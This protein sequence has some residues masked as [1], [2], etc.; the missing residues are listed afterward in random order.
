MKNASENVLVFP[1]PSLSPSMVVPVSSRL[2]LTLRAPFAF[3]VGSQ[4]LPPGQ[5]YLE[6]QMSW[7][8]ERNVVVICSTDGEIYH[9]ACAINIP[10][11]SASRTGR[12]VFQRLGGQLYLSEIQAAQQPFLI[13]LDFGAAY[14]RQKQASPAS[15]SLQR[16]ELKLTSAL[17]TSSPVPL[18]VVSA[19]TPQL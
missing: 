9:A 17:P 5:Y 13:R 15:T 2:Q 8:S 10:L 18:P 11:H 19:D 1:K 14:P 16:L 7:D 6:P 3:T 12:A 4:I